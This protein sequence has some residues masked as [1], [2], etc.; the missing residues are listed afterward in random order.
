MAP[1]EWTESLSDESKVSTKGAL[2]ALEWQLEMKGSGKKVG[3]QGAKRTKLCSNQ[4]GHAFEGGIF[5]G[6][7]MIAQ[8]VFKWE[9]KIRFR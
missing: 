3:E 8:K 4:R 2:A 6:C 9:K 7:K 1:G 5:L